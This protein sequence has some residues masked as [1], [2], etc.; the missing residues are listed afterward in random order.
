MLFNTA[1]YY[2]MTQRRSGVASFFLWG[3]APGARNQNDVS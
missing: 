3:G 2:V 1:Y